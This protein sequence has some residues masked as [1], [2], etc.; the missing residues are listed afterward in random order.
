METWKA[1][2]APEAAGPS[3]GGACWGG[4]RSLSSPG[5]SDIR[6]E[7]WPRVLEWLGHGT[8]KPRAL[9]LAWR[10]PGAEWGLPSPPR[11]RPQKSVLQQIQR[12][13]PHPQCTPWRG[14]GAGGRDPLAHS[15]RRRRREGGDPCR[16]RA[17]PTTPQS[18]RA[19]PAGE[20]AYLRC[21]IHQGQHP[22]CGPC[23]AWGEDCIVSTQSPAPPPPNLISIPGKLL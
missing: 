3:G 9:R 8:Q 12:C 13:R 21:W 23:P 20:Q 16:T 19:G 17:H 11:R 4:G 5:L 1:R 14:G 15:H 7:Q 18:W 22:D 6:P 10:T 2:C